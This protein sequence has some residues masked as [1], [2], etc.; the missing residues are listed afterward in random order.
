MPSSHA[1]AVTALATSVGIG[2]G[3]SSAAFAIAV[4]LAII[5]MYDASHVRRAVGEQNEALLQLGKKAGSK[6]NKP[7]QAVGHTKKQVIVGAVLGVVVGM[8]AFFVQ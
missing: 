2:E 3:L 6:I 7:F 8:L 5:V 4:V 1:A